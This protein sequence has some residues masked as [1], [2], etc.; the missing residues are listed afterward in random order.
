MDCGVEV[1]W[2]K[3][4][5]NKQHAENHGFKNWPGPASPTGPTISGS[6]F[7]F[8]TVSWAY[9]RLERHRTE[10][11]CEP[12]NPFY[13]FF[14]SHQNDA[15]LFSIKTLPP[16]PSSNPTQI[17][18]WA[19]PLRSSWCWPPVPVLLQTKRQGWHVPGCCLAAA[20]AA[21]LFQLLPLPPTPLIF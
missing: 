5:K 21:P 12:V 18:P 1:F 20:T 7:R 9:Q 19:L 17:C 10:W 14:P 3:E 8:N 15:V 2:V 4:L 6:Q 11:T 16:P 13:L